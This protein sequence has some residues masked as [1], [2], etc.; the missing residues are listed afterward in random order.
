[1]ASISRWSSRQARYNTVVGMEIASDSDGSGGRVL[2]PW[3]GKDTVGARVW[4]YQGAEGESVFI[5]VVPL[6]VSV[7]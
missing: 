3:Y 7:G 4:Q 1:V 2:D 5:F 6:A